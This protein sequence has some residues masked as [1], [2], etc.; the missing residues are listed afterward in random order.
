MKWYFV[1]LGILMLV[2]A[3]SCWAAE[4]TTELLSDSDYRNMTDGVLVEYG[5]DLNYSSFILDSFVKGNISRE[6]ALASTISAYVLNIH[7]INTVLRVEP[8]EKFSDYHNY[9]TLMLSDFQMYLWNIAKFYETNNGN[10]ALSAREKY[11]STTKNY[12]N[13]L[14]ERVLNF[15]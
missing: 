15:A 12:E 2:S 3:N 1:L 8:A 10:Y 11:N 5:E 7:S 13:A 9:L 14:Q 6:S 4:N